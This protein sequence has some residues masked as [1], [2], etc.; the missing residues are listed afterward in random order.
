[1]FRQFHHSTCLAAIAGILYSVTAAAQTNDNAQTPAERL[2][3]LDETYTSNLRK[4]HAPIIQEYLISLGKLKQTMAQR[5]RPERIADVQDEIDLVKHIA[6]TSGLLPYDVLQREQQGFMPAERSTPEPITNKSPKNKPRDP[7]L[8]LATA[9]AK[10]FSPALASLTVK[11]DGRAVPVGAVEWVIDKIPAG[12]YRISILYSCAGKPADTSIIARLG[13]ISV[14]R[15][16]TAA[17][18]TGGI[19]EFRIASLGD[20]HLD[21]SLAGTSLV[22][23]NA[24]PTVAAIWVRQVIIIKATENEKK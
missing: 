24:D 6:T 8:I 17:N 12:D 11:P 21:K 19:N 2:E 20:F 18:A 9:S 7:A 15:A 3:Q 16:F 4:Y 22:L 14:P 1:M 10:R 23:Q 5:G 13:S